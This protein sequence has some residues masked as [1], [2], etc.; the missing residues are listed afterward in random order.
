MD[1]SGFL[2]ALRRLVVLW[3]AAGAIALSGCTATAA[4]TTSLSVGSLASRVTGRQ[5][6]ASPVPSATAAALRQ[7][8]PTSTSTAAPTATP[9]PPATPTTLPT[10][11]PEPTATILP[12]LL[13]T[14]ATTMTAMPTPAMVLPAADS[15]TLINGIPFSAI[16]VIPPDIAAHVQAILLR[17]QE[18]GRNP[19]A[20]SKLGDSLV[21]TDH[22]LTRFDS[23]GY[24]LGPFAALQPTV[25]Y[26]NGSF[27]RF[28]VAARVGLYADFATRPGLANGEWCPAEEHMLACEFRLHN[29]S[30]LLVR[31]GTNDV[32][33]ASAFETALHKIVEYALESG[34]VPVLGT[35]ADRFEGDNRNNDIIRKVAA[36]YRVPLW[37]FDLVAG[38]LPERGLSGDNAHLS[39][40]K[41]NDY[42]DP[43][44]L[45]AGYPVSDL[46][47]LV[48]LD[49]VRALAPAP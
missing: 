36:D 6:T 20:F 18:L 10:V 33:T 12:T 24:S 42:T 40:Y 35:K 21:L 26:F 9:L 49:A 15:A 8:V 29:P 16:A 31:V 14:V 22:Y 4:A 7:F 1:L 13:P 43:D 27:A 3:L 45:K 17:G 41:H 37:D 44:T 38:T 39:V 47:A 19:R 32:I 34:V 2:G 48:V 11:T 25:D 28:G 46:T 5:E 23:G 30:I